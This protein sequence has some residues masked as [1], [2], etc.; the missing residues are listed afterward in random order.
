MPGWSICVGKC[1]HWG[2]GG[3]VF[4]RVHGLPDAWWEDG[5]G[6]WWEESRS[7]HS[8]LIDNNDICS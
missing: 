6:V 1:D 4:C 7:N 3:N 8:V 5:R 2:R